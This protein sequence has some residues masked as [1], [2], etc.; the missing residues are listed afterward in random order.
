MSANSDIDSTVC[1][2][3]L[4]SRLSKIG[5]VTVNTPGRDH[6]MGYLKIKESLSESNQAAPSWKKFK[7]SIS[8]SGDDL[9][10][11]HIGTNFR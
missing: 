11:I 7:L 10:S 1:G 8:G 9:F 2:K 4:G 3:K 5:T 6:R